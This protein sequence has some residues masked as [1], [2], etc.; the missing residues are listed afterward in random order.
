MASGEVCCRTAARAI[1]QSGA[2]AR[3]RAQLLTWRGVYPEMRAKAAWLTSARA[4]RAANSVCNTS[5]L[6]D[7]LF[8][9]ADSRIGLTTILCACRDD[10][11]GED[12]NGQAD[13]DH[14]F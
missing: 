1:A 6:K 3:P 4:S 12:P 9:G 13:R 7:R 11:H 10:L 8:A 14:P 5:R 2:A